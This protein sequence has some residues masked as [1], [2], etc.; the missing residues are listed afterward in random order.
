M[1]I[2]ALN[3]RIT[4]QQLKTTI[5]ENGFDVEEWLDVK[6]VWAAVSNLHSKEYFEAA[7][8]QMENTVKFT[9][10]YLPTLDTS[11]RI[12]FNNTLY[13]IISVDNIKYRNRFVEIKGLEVDLSG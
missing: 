6:S 4:F 3:K 13:N 10:R 7:A 2:G 9:I 1:E 5:N 12:L 11:M 8:V